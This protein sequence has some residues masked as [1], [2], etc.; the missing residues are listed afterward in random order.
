M[1]ELLVASKSLSEAECGQKM[2]LSAR[3]PPAPS[4]HPL[5]L[6]ASSQHYKMGPRALS[7][8]RALAKLKALLV[9]II[10]GSH[11]AH[12]GTATR[13]NQWT[14]VFRGI[15]KLTGQGPFGSCYL[16]NTQLAHHSL[17]KP[18]WSKQSPIQTVYQELPQTTFPAIAARV[19]NLHTQQNVH[20]L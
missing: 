11:L 16:L 3:L 7:S 4:M 1:P 15:S 2:V 12:K 13:A 14:C 9:P 8:C 6:P 19:C 18:R 5:S 20:S 10:K 17:P